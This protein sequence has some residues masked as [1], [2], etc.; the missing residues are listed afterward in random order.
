MPWAEIRWD[1]C[2]RT[3]ADAA[4]YQIIVGRSSGELEGN[5]AHTSFLEEVMWDTYPMSCRCEYGVSMSEGRFKPNG[6]DVGGDEMEH[7]FPSALL[8]GGSD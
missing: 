5:I 2:G 7:S 8:L 3:D 1:I 4:R 6:G